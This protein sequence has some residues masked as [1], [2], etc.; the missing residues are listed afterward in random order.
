MSRGLEGSLNRGYALC[1]CDAESERQNLGS[2][3]R[4]GALGDF[5]CG[6][7]P[8]LSQIITTV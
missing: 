5:D 3:N 8:A 4:R 6:S 1:S 2:R 7:F